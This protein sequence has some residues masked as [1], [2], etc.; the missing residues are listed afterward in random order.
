MLRTKS[1]RSIK[2]LKIDKATEKDTLED[3]ILPKAVVNYPKKSKKVA[4]NMRIES[5]AVELS[6]KLASLKHL[7]GYTQLLRIYIWEGLERDKRVLL[8]GNVKDI[9][10]GQGKHH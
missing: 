10:K 6:K 5:E 4:L 2:D 7:D 3:A 9:Y 1:K 8:G